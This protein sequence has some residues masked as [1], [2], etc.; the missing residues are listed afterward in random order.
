MKKTA[1]LF[2]FT[3]FFLNLAKAETITV[4]YFLVEPH[5]NLKNGKHVGA[6]ID[7]WK[8]HVSPKMNVNIKFAGPYPVPRLINEAIHG[9]INVIALLAKNQERIKILDFPD[10]PFVININAIAFLKGHK[11]EKINKIDNLR[12]MNLGFFAKG[13]I[14]PLLKNNNIKWSL[15]Y[16]TDWSKINLK[17]L[18]YRR[19][20]GFYSPNLNVLKYNISINNIKDKVKILT[21]PGTETGLYSLFSKK[22]KG[23]YLKIYNQVH[24]QVLEE[25]SYL[26]LVEKYMK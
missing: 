25:V 2:F 17:L 8:D 18:S 15:T 23:R 19:I 26:D 13:F 9:K 12:G 16:K 22:D 24:P 14:H 20:D 5:S 21:I 10:K 11:I 1:F 6:V 7:Y 3:A 4:G